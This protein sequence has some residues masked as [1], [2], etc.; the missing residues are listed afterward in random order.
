MCTDKLRPYPAVFATPLNKILVA[1]FANKAHM[2]RRNPDL[3]SMKFPASAGLHK[4]RKQTPRDTGQD[5]DLRYGARD[6][7][8]IAAPVHLQLEKF[9]RG[10][11][12][13]GPSAKA[14]FGRDSCSTMALKNFNVGARATAGTSEEND[15][16]EE[17]FC[18]II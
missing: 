16:E 8:L 7:R 9:A 15:L 5:Q 3:H 11:D 6:L 17:P 18:R 1:G 14:Q 10:L 4:W 13:E 2:H 12:A